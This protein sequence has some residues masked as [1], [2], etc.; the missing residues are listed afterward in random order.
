M[1]TVLKISFDTIN[2]VVSQFYDVARND[3]LIGFHFR[4]IQ[5][6]DEH[7]PRISN[8]WQLQLTGE[9][10]RKEELPFKLIEVHL[11]LKVTPGQIDRWVFLFLENLENQEV[12]AKEIRSE[13]EKKVLHFAKKLKASI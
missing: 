1:E 6:F 5:N 4:H 2:K 10:N 12:L 8:F 13:W 7:I 9:I 11:P 3:I